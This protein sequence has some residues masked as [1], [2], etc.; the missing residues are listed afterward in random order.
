MRLSA[1]GIG[2]LVQGVEQGSVQG[3]ERRMQ[4]VECRMQGVERRMQDV[5]CRA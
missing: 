2:C 5:G 4:D 1:W 3:V